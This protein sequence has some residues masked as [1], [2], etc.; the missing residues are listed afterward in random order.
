MEKVKKVAKKLVK[1]TTTK[2]K[3]TKKTQFVQQKN[4]VKEPISFGRVLTFVFKV[5]TLPLYMVYL[6][7]FKIPNDGPAYVVGFLR[8]V[9]FSTVAYYS[10]QNHRLDSFI[11]D[12]A[13]SHN[14]ISGL[15]ETLLG[16]YAIVM[17]L[18]L[19][20]SFIEIFGFSTGSYWHDPYENASK[21]SYS[22]YDAIEKGINYR[23]SLLRAKHTPGKIRELKKTGF[24]TAERL[25][26]MGSSPEVDSAL[27][28]LNSQ[29]RAMHGP[30]KLN[31]LEKMFGG[32]Q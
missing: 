11:K 26:G 7:L 9:F 3:S 20:L 24:I 25:S 28:L 19:G 16:I 4:F 32:K 2:R 21:N 10:E 27:S 1:N 6:L 8:F 18:N 15:A 30:D 17:L 23:D 5:I 29:M 12:Y 14:W 13:I 22:G 31:T